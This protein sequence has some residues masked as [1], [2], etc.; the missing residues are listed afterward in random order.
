MGV[1][2][3]ATLFGHLVASAGFSSSQI[4]EPANW[5]AAPEVFMNAFGV[6]IYVLNLVTTLA[7]IFSAVRGQRRAA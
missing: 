5:R 1:A 2:L 3:S 4:G 6:T 7:I